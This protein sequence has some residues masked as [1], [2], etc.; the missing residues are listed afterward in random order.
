MLEYAT[1]GL[2]LLSLGMYV[3]LDGYDLGVGMLSLFDRGERRRPYIELIATAWDANESWI[4]LAGVVMWAGLPGV[5]A[6]V[7]PGVYL[8]LIGMLM[9][10][11]LRGVGLEMQSAA[12]GYR[13]GWALLFGIASVTATVCQGLVIGTV[14]SGLSQ[15]GGSFDGPV[16]GWISPY[17]VLCALGLLV[18]HLL[19]G[20]AWLQD[21][22]EG[23]AR[24]RAG[25]AGRPLLVGTAIATLILGFGLEVADPMTFHFDQPW[26]AAVYWTAVA[27][28]VVG[29]AL[30][31]HGF[32]RRPDWRPFVG[33][34][35]AE[36]CGLVA[37]VAATVPIVVPADLTL[38]QA[39]SPSSS[40]LFLVVGVGL[41]MPV[42]LAYNTYAWWAFR[43]KYADPAVEPLAPLRRSRPGRPAPAEER[44]TPVVVA[45]R[46]GVVLLVVVLA[47]MAQ[48]VFG[49]VSQWLD[50]VGIGVLC[51]FGLV[52]WVV[53]E[54]RDHRD[55]LFDLEIDAEAE[56]VADAGA[57]AGS[58]PMASG[59]QA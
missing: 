43:G 23:P 28:A 26:R 5:Y 21:K 58:G 56:G 35:T 24:E 51:A 45:R 27:G 39:S 52:V 17:S 13:R 16:Y 25:R 15:R 12:R 30:A 32:G 40:Q 8:P 50:P 42:V 37:L 57:D 47:A 29:G 9:S 1:Y 49:G 11:I 41:C 19:A 33:V 31:W 44:V 55:G 3:V 2:V 46:L 20:A 22:T 36:V 18:V 38:R 53:G 10:I 54:R 34:V 6:T 14:L 7:L 59:E 4:V 48:D